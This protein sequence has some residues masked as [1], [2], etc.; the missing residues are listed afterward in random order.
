MNLPKSM[1]TPSNPVR[2]PTFPNPVTAH[3]LSLLKYLAFLETQEVRAYQPT[4]L[5]AN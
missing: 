3:T 5:F 4:H 1:H 2:A